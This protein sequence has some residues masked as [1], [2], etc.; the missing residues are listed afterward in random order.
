MNKAA[1]AISKK[2]DSGHQKFV[3]RFP[4][5]LHQ[6]IRARA[7]LSRRSMNSEIILRLE[8]SLGKTNAV[9]TEEP[10][11]EK[12]D[13]RKPKANNKSPLLLS[14]EQKERVNLALML[15]AGKQRALRNLLKSDK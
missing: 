12:L 13:V 9:D 8:N 5:E 11:L 10:T 14:S 2:S 6:R 15:P 3:V 4:Q 1:K 7:R